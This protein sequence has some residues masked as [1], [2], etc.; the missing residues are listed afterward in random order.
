MAI[1][2]SYSSADEDFAKI[3]ER[4]LSAN[5]YSTWFAPK[6]IGASQS[7]VKEIVK[8]L[9]PHVSESEE[10]R[11]LEAQ[12]Q[13]DNAQY[14]ILL[15]S[16]NS[17]RSKWVRR[18]FL[19]ADK[20][21]IPMQVLH[22]DHSNLTSDWELML[23]DNQIIDCYHMNPTALR[24]V[25]AKLHHDLPS[26]NSAT[27]RKTDLKRFTYEEIG[28]FPI[29]SGDP[30]FTEG[31][32]LRI[33]LGKGRFFLAPP[34][35]L[36]ADPENSD[37]L[38]IHHFHREDKVFDTTLDEACSS[39]PVDGLRQMI[40]E[41]RRKIFQQ[42]LHGENGCY[43]NNEKYG[44]EKISGFERTE[45][46]A[47]RP[48]LRVEMFLTDYFTHRVIKDVC[49]QLAKTHREFI[50]DMDFNN[51]GSNRIL[52]TSLGINLILKEGNDKVLLTSRSTNAAETY[53]RHSYSLSAIEGVSVSDYDNFNQSVNVQLTVFRGL[54]EELGVDESYVMKD[55]LKFYNLFVNPEN[56]EMGLSCSVELRP[57]YTLA[58]DII[59][60]HGKDEKLEVSGKKVVNVK[61]LRTFIYNNLAGILPQALFTLCTYL[62]SI[63]IFMIDRLHHSLLLDKHSVIAK[64]GTPSLCGDTYVWS[65]NYIAVIDGATPKGEML[66]DGQKGDVYV[67][68]LVAD[69]IT[70]MDPGYTAQEGITH[71]NDVV[72]AA[73]T[74]HGV[75]FEELTPAERLQCS[76]LIYSVRRHEVWSFG[77]CML[78]INNHDFRNIKEVDNLFA[79]LRAF[80]IQ[81]ERDR[82]GAN[83]DESELSM[84]GREQILP[85]LK[86]Q[87]TLANRNVPF[88]YDVIDGGQIDPDNVT[89]YAVQKD[90][91]VVMASDGYP[92]LFNT[93]E[94]TEEYLMEALREDPTCVGRLR[95]TKGVQPGNQSYDDRT[96]VSFRVR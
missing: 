53:N 42:F 93:L 71:I 21:N 24:K 19:I 55:S 83:A 17:M 60:L 6:S 62:D 63:G 50:M 70:V 72:R 29:S 46:M 68:H 87:N 58:K 31:D 41:S 7:F 38:E 52:F 85:Y 91:C 1:F 84:Y 23:V 20:H 25:M 89:I 67:S 75:D 8:E 34:E 79:A 43:F 16:A 82:R 18:E 28:L 69:A 76:V 78:R 80:C 65:D 49:K 45:D 44:V 9:T 22:I 48:V 4:A 26:R 32:T 90:D 61:E 39:I 2:I 77:D 96:Y 5:N 36:L 47:E 13:L 10:G 81:I 37:Y 54:Q 35:D 51:I 94:D 92:K 40:E 66:W 15:L 88:G 12:E 59:Q 27:S 56:L 73:Y 57:Q 33:R 64:D 30:F 86:E 11:I 3:L 14:Y 95:G 74:A